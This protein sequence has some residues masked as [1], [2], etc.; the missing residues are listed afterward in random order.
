[1]R[2]IAETCT[3][4]RKSQIA[5]EYCFRKLQENPACSVFWVNAATAARFEE[6][7][8]RIA[9]ACLL[10]HEEGQDDSIT[11]VQRWLE[12]EY[13]SPW[14]M[15]IDNVDDETA[16][17]H[18]KC[19][20]NRT[21]YQCLPRCSH[22]KL[23]FTSRTRDVAVDLASPLMPINVASMTTEEGLE[24]MRKRLGPDPPE[25]HLI[26]L[27]SELEH[28]PL[29]VTQ[30]MSF[31]LKRRKSVQQYLDLYRMG[32]HSRN[33]LLSYEFLDHGRQQ[34]T[35][36]SVARTLT[37]SFDWIRNHHPKSAEIMCL[38]S[39]YQHHGVPAQL[40]R[41]DDDMDLF[42]FEDSIAVLQAFSLLEV[43]ESGTMYSTHRLIQMTAKWWLDQ[44]DPAQLEKRALQAL[45][46]ITRRFPPPS[47]ET[48][49]DYWEHCQSLLP[50]AE[51]LLHQKFKMSKRESDLTRARLLICTGK[52]L[53]W[54]LVGDWRDVQRRFQESFDI[55][56]SYLGPKHFDT[57]KAMG[58][59]FWSGSRGSC[60]LF[61][62]DGKGLMKLG[63]ELLELRRE[64]LG[65]RHPDTIDALS[66]VAGLL[67]SLGNL[68]ESETMQREALTISEE[69]NGPT[70]HETTNCRTHLASVLD[71]MG[72][73]AESVETGTQAVM[74][75]TKML[76]PEHR[77]VLVSRSDL[78][79]YL[80]H[81]GRFD[82]SCREH[83]EVITLKEKVYGVENPETLI[84]VRNLAALLAQRERYNEAVDV[85]AHAMSLFRA[86]WRN[87]VASV[88]YGSPQAIESLKL[89]YELVARESDVGAIT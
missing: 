61:D 39:F 14:I 82:E 29:A 30:S 32:D 11:L 77:S 34:Q 66:D 18:D 31:I 36:D 5:L 89:R 79:L 60:S 47:R 22:G 58:F 65:S 38:M 48:T 51:V 69:V 15:V 76:G 21:P 52:Y 72:K 63:Y 74:M 28:I 25:G 42:E 87:R 50:H 44:E 54:L 84:T 75:F 10:G 13:V 80:S 88:D 27:L 12:A 37:L 71:S 53:G 9:R 26:E 67:E 68:E 19:R 2:L 17:L 6:S 55:R 49:G 41:L 4:H 3:P 7:F 23:L 62:V 46:I 70:H 45:E 40:L 33:R 81:S 8:Q 24:L 86:G 83:K 35:M 59:V 85:L 73:H 64:V 78:A 56:Q 57:L 16:F 43:N 1:M 20:N